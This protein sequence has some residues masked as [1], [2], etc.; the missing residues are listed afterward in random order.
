MEKVAVTLRAVV[1]QLKLLR[2][3]SSARGAV[4]FSNELCCLPTA[5]SVLEVPQ[6][7]LNA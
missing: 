6:P 1:A 3:R 2:S 4:S 5:D 7:I